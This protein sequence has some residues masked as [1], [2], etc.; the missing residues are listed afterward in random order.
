MALFSNNEP[1]LDERI[2]K[3]HRI[4]RSRIP[5]ARMHLF[6]NGTKLTMEKFVEIVQYLD[7]LIINNYNEKNELN[8][9][10]RLVVEYCAKHPELIKKVTIVM[11]HPYEVLE[12]RGGTAPN[13]KKRAVY[14]NAKCT[15]PFRQM[16]VR[17]NGKVSLCCNDAIGV[18]DMG[19]VERESLIDIWYGDKFNEAREILWSCGRERISICKYCDSFRIV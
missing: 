16:I 19:D 10:Q 12:T 17:S 18:T 6:T 15:H 9:N 3:F 4:V 2:I 11:R 13:R 8:N 7:E 1:F 14:S 5:K